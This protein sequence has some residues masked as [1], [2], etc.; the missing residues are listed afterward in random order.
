LKDLD[1]SRVGPEK[2]IEEERRAVRGNPYKEAEVCAKKLSEAGRKRSAYQDQQAE[3]LI[4]LDELRSKLAS[5]VEVRSVALKELEALRSHREQMERLE[6]DA[7][8]LLEHYVGM[9]PE[10]LDILTSKER[11][12]IDKMPRLRVVVCADE[13]VEI[14]GVFGGPLEAHTSCPVKSE[15]MWAAIPVDE[16]RPSLLL[17]CRNA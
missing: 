12:S 5:L 2:L 14:T 6:C 11:H 16:R 7:D 10:T 8:A 3:G 9:I 13:P 1:R 4:T 17:V 15:A